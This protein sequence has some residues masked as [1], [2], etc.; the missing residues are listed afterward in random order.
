MALLILIAA[1]PQKSAFH[2][3]TTEVTIK[4]RCPK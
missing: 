3:S 4:K 1:C 2:L